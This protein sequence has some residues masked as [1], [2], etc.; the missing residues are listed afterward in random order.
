MTVRSEAEMIVITIWFFLQ[1]I[2][3]AMQ[4]LM[5]I[6]SKGFVEGFYYKPRVDLQ[7][8][9]KYH[10]GMIALSACLAGEVARFLTRGMYEDAKA[11]ALQISGYFWKGKLSSW[12]CRIM[13]FR[14]SR[15]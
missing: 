5:K 7:L 10:E 14:S 8:L 11:A 3:R 4:N 15:M 13:E 1:K 9:E 2:T 12:N 6:V